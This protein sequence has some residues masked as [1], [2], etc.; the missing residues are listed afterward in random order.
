MHQRQ[1]F[2]HKTL[3]NDL[4]L[5]YLQ[6]KVIEDLKHVFHQYTIRTDRRE[7][8]EEHLTQ[9]GIGHGVYYPTPVHKLP[10]FEIK[11][12][13]PE[14]ELAAREV[15]S[16]PVHPLLTDEDVGEVIEAMNSWT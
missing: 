9:K 14:T 11:I 4:N 6:S 12:D 5:L 1:K 3:S 10:S 7:S 16:I 8:L 2:S 13:L 15:L